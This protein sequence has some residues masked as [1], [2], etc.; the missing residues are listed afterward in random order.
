MCEFTL[1][2]CDT[3]SDGD[4]INDNCEAPGCEFNPDPNACVV[5]APPPILDLE[6]PAEVLCNDAD[7]DDVCDDEDNCPNAA[8]TD[9]A[10]ADG[11]QFGDVC[12][13]CPAD[14]TNDA[15]DSDGVCADVDNC[16]NTANTNQANADGD[17]FGDACDP[18]PFDPTNDASDNDGVCD[19]VDNCLGLANPDQSD[20]DGD[21][22]GDACDICIW[23]S[24][25]D[26]D[27]DGACACPGTLP[28]FLFAT[29]VPIDELERCDECPGDA[30][31]RLAGICGCGASDVDTDGDCT[32]DC[33]DW[34]PGDP[35][36]IAAGWCGC[37]IP[38][39]DDDGDGIPNCVD[40]CPA[41]GS[42]EPTECRCVDP[43][44]CQ[45]PDGT[46]YAEVG[47]ECLG[48]TARC[49]PVCAGHDCDCPP[50]APCA[51]HG[52]CYPTEDD[53][54][55]CR[56]GTQ[57]CPAT[58][59]VCNPA[60]EFEA[61]PCGNTDTVCLPHSF[62]GVHQTDCSCP[63]EAP[64]MHDGACFAMV[65]S[66]GDA[67]SFTDQQCSPGSVQCV[68]NDWTT[69]DGRGDAYARQRPARC[70]C[71]P[72][73]P[74]HY[75][76]SCSTYQEDGQCSPGTIECVG[77]SEA[78]HCESLNCVNGN[79]DHDDDDDD[80][81]FF[82]ICLPAT[83]DDGIRNQGE[84]DVDCGGPNC[85]RC[86]VGEICRD[87]S[88]CDGGACE[89]APGVTVVPPVGECPQDD[90]GSGY[91]ALYESMDHDGGYE[92]PPLFPEGADGG[93]PAADYSQSCQL[94]LPL[95]DFLDD[96]GAECGSVAG[97][98]TDAPQG[99]DVYVIDLTG[100][101]YVGP[102]ELTVHLD[103]CGPTGAQT[104]YDSF[105]YV[106]QGCQDTIVA[107]NDD[108]CGLQPEL[109]VGLPY[110]HVYYVHQAGF[111]SGVGDYVLH[112]SIGDASCGVRRLSEQRGPAGVCK[113][114][115]QCG[116]DE[117]CDARDGQCVA[118]DRVA[119]GLVDACVD[120]IDSDN[121]GVGDACDICPRDPFN[122]SDGDG[123]CADVD[124]CP[125]DPNKTTPGACGCGYADFD[126]EYDGDGLTGGNAGDWFGNGVCAHVDAI[127][128][129]CAAP[130][131]D[132]G[133]WNGDEDMVDCGG[134][135]DACVCPEPLIAYQGSC[136]C[137]PGAEW[138]VEGCESECGEGF[139]RDWDGDLQCHPDPTC[140]DGEQN[141]GETDVDCGGPCAPCAL[142][143]GCA[144][145][146]DCAG[147]PS[148]VMCHGGICVSQSQCPCQDPASPCHYD[149]ACFP[150]QG[151]SCPAGTTFCQIAC[152]TC[153]ANEIETQPC[154]G[155][156]VH[157][158][159][160]APNPN[161]CL[162]G[163]NAPC[164][165]AET[166]CVPKPDGSDECPAEFDDCPACECREDTPCFYDGVC[167]PR[168]GN[169][170][171]PGTYECPNLTPLPPPPPPPCD[172]PVEAPCSHEGACYPRNQGGCQAG[173]EDCYGCACP[174]DFPCWYEGHCSA[175]VDGGC[176]AGTELCMVEV[177]VLASAWVAPVV[178][179]TPPA[180]GS[181]SGGD[182]NQ[183]GDSTNNDSNAADTAASGGAANGS[184][185]D[186]EVT[187]S[188]TAS[189]E[190]DSASDV[191]ESVSGSSATGD[192][193]ASET[194]GNDGTAGT[195]SDN[196]TSETGSVSPGAS[197]DGAASDADSE[198]SAAQSEVG[199]ASSSSTASSG[200]S[201][202]VDTGSSARSA[203][204][205][206]GSDASGS[207][208]SS[209]SAGGA[210]SG[211]D[212]AS[213]SANEQSSS[214]GPT[215]SE[216]GS[217]TLEGS[218]SDAQASSA[219]SDGEGATDTATETGS[220]T[221]T[222]GEAKTDDSGETDGE[223]KTGSGADESADGAIHVT[224]AATSLCAT[225]DTGSGPCRHPTSGDC[226]AV[227]AT[228]SCPASYF[229]CSLISEES[230]SAGQGNDGV[231]LS[232]VVLS[233]ISA[234]QFDEAAQQVFLRGI[235]ASTGVAVSDIV[236]VA[237]VDTVET[238]NR[239]L[240]A[241]VTVQFAVIVAETA[242]A[243]DIHAAVAG[244]ASKDVLS[245]ALLDDGATAG[246]DSPPEFGG[247]Q[248]AQPDMGAGLAT[249]VDDTDSS[250]VFT[251]GLV[252]AGAVVVAVAAAKMLVGRRRAS[253]EVHKIV[254]E[255]KPRAVTEASSRDASGS[256]GASG[257]EDED[258]AKDS[259]VRSPSK[260]VPRATSAWD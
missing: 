86:T 55:V 237:I 71:G 215:G 132:D 191:A 145:Q 202:G 245:D 105:L 144:S 66:A 63:P 201:S 58:C 258:A 193:D 222:D 198:A 70:P 87:T 255:K 236:I 52:R 137:G 146:H 239:R 62:A 165:H 27:G 14:S 1:T 143:G 178:P 103:N 171:S 100:P 139:W 256:S 94:A 57:W 76:G 220:A 157:D 72:E 207:S 23:T 90:D 125:N 112:F 89:R 185:S 53:S 158:R 216:D 140:T 54:G 232:S 259:S 97:S 10:N 242:N 91:G 24:G 77:C 74:C 80:P 200:D 252:A 257:S 37:G 250:V 153:E 182:D 50:E 189:G 260:I 39:T 3:D 6:D 231:I 45:H 209:A 208:T 161:Y 148:D 107:A 210:S 167:S 60:H 229:A 168:V 67:G 115:S 92:L 177:N 12:D 21:G 49:Q 240:A 85:S 84:S 61:V 79:A 249:P 81:P 246:V 176:S 203:S 35:A 32:A 59:T 211:S 20:V 136:N 117:R 149:G 30:N 251:A 170:C 195:D 16:P 151:N 179:D 224:V 162:C 142:G 48:E 46:C 186:G 17:Q 127:P 64:C 163:T 29:V 169:E 124:S 155:P 18:C 98:T 226:A 156:G 121:D 173:T 34:C 15:A 108:A 123:A 138:V 180:K 51:Q 99:R 205:A 228:G 56:P 128:L 93:P 68:H 22:I 164:F 116:A 147:D 101:E 25:Q 225:C 2:A 204:A 95:L 69:R 44:P 217:T 13:P 248:A 11:D 19:D 8:N 131:C 65:D 187:G 253:N 83:C 172:C 244:I 192:D 194:G 31:K 223:T 41:A 38:E 238:R 184:T 33:H 42:E 230:V 196:D 88:D 126:A 188:E 190:S 159:Q 43:A 129:R 219:G 183:Q 106:Y 154:T 235:A 4:T 212:S 221:E 241:G 141:G 206:S 110:G 214:S 118:D 133:L 113:S 120:P 160:C 135:C 73:A 114:S 28:G 82:G 234:A 150:P 96:D 166:G 75:Q 7:N 213:S 119:R 174:Q 122:D 111:G 26:L 47:G 175:E 9:Q 199:E 78:I 104:T 233:G 130:T 134:T 152:T 5:G 197:S 247:A 181:G 40:P 243:E 102:G 254:P 36:K 227:A 109:D 218:D